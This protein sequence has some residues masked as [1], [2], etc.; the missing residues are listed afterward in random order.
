MSKMD[1]MR[2]QL[3]VHSSFQPSPVVPSDNEINDCIEGEV[4]RI[5]SEKKGIQSNM[6]LAKRILDLNPKL[7]K[8]YKTKFEVMAINAHFATNVSVVIN[9]CI[10][11][12]IKLKMNEKGC[13][14]KK[15]KK[16]V[17]N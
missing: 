8:A 13:I 3:D 15:I 1:E 14:I 4:S 17:L 2:A 6:N 10:D 11:K 9:D 16:G 7:P 12:G 5:Y